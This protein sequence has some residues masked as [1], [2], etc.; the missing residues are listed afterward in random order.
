MC[1]LGGIELGQDPRILPLTIYPIGWSV[2][3]D[4]NLPGVTHVCHIYSSQ[5]G[6]TCVLP[7]FSIRKNGTQPSSY[8]RGHTRVDTTT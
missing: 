1:R 7:L 5:L 2:H 6:K 4:K 8:C 3:R